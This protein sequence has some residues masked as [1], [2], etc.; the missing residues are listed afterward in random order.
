MGKRKQSSIYEMQEEAASR[1]FI[2]LDGMTPE[3]ARSLI[4]ELDPLPFCYKVGLG[5][6]AGVALIRLVGAVASNML[7]RRV[8]AWIEGLVEGASGGGGVIPE[9]ATWAMMLVGFGAVG[10]AVR[11]KERLTRVSA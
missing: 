8:I 7:G 10:F 6:I 5:L 11:R 1:I 3:D 2:A 9:P 4:L